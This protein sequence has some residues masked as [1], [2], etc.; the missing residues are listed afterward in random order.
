MVKVKELFK[1]FNTVKAVDGISFEVAEGDFLTLLGPSGSG[2]TTTLMMI[3][4]FE[5]PTSGDIRVRG[6]SVVALPP[7]RRNIGMVFQNYA[8]FPHLT[9]YENIAFPLK[10]RKAPKS[11]IREKVHAVLDLVRLGGVEERFPNQLSG[12]Q[13]QRIALA[14]AMVFDPPLLLMDE[15]LGALDKKLRE[16]MQLE[17]KQ[18]QEEVGI[19]IIY[20]THDQG[21]ALTM[22]NRIAIMNAGRIEQIGSPNEVYERPAN[23]FVADFIGESNFLEGTVVSVERKNLLIRTESGLQFKALAR[24]PFLKGGKATVSLRP[25]KIFL[26]SKGRKGKPINPLAGVVKDVIYIGEIIRYKIRL[27][28][29]ELITLKEQT[30]SDRKQF[31]KGEKVTVGWLPEDGIVF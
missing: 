6:A 24:K 14:R 20:V 15:P 12:G 10:M 16:H 19:T 28:K 1:N 8:L 5:Y 13:Q 11:T 26:V 9:I 7:Y 27:G 3:A 29:N 30:R 31:K 4:G 2:K 23:K 25:E 17:I 18:I 22:S 21:E